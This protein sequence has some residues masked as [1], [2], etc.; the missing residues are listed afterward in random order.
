MDVG[1]GEEQCRHYF[2]VL[3]IPLHIQWAHT[4]SD[5]NRAGRRMF[6]LAKHLLFLTLSIVLR[7]CSPILHQHLNSEFERLN[8]AFDRRI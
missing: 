6:E 1:A 5:K 3:Y 4:I 8:G 7:M 2:G